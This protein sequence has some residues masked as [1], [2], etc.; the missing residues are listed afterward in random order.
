MF[1]WPKIKKLYPLHIITL[2]YIAI[3]VII[4]QWNNLNLK[5]AVL[6]LFSFF[7]N[8]TLTQSWF[9]SKIVFFSYNGVAWYLSV[10]VFLYFAFPFINK[11][12]KKLSNKSLIIIAVVIY[13]TQMVLSVGVNM[14]PVNICFLDISESF[15]DWITYTL[16]IFRAG[17]FTIG[18]ILGYLYISKKTEFESEAQ[19]NDTAKY[20]FFEIIV[21]IVLSVAL[22]LS[23]IYLWHNSKLMDGLLNTTIV[24]LPSSVLLVYVFAKNKG[25]ITR[26]LTNRVTVYLG[27]I[28]S[29]I[30]LFHQLP[31]KT[32]HI[33]QNNLS[34]FEELLIILMATLVLS[35]LYRILS[36]YIKSRKKAV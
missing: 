12:L 20:T 16:P 11:T 33:R 28:S 26:A 21:L 8:I 34:G 30:F 3:T 6:N 31:I 35:E 36:K 32:L 4:S 14:I 13:L 27:D 2:F 1:S 23:K 17:D 10:C 18:C 24:F 15:Y 7:A 19:K 9:P 22:Y 25:L 29:F 5:H